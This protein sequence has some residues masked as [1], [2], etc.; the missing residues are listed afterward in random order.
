VPAKG[1]AKWGKDPTIR[2]D[3]PRICAVSYCDRS[4]KMYFRKDR[5]IWGNN[6]YCNQ[7]AKTSQRTYTQHKKDTCEKCGF[8]P[9]N[10]CQLDVDHIDGSKFNNKL[11]NLQTLCANCH[12]LKTW[13]KK[14]HGGKL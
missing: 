2:P 1:S 14:D 7:H 6:S 10:M 3:N 12:R 4:T 9:E 11:S 8:I 13:D 5:Q